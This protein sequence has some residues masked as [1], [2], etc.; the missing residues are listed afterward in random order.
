MGSSV[1]TKV[2]ITGGAMPLGAARRRARWPLAL[3]ALPAAVYLA[4][5]YFYPMAAIL[6]ASF[7]RATAGAGAAVAEVLGSPAYLRIIGFTFFQATLSTLITLAV[8]LPGAYLL[9]RYEFR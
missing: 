9:A 2:Q 6:Q 5:F 3:L 8:G 1:G 4:L 7:A